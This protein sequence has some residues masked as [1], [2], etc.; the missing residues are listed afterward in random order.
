MK[1]NK[2]IEIFRELVGDNAENLSGSFFPAYANTKI[3]NALL[4]EN[5]DLEDNE[6]VEVDSIGMDLVCWQR[7]AAFI[8]ALVLFP[9]KFTDEDIQDEVASLLIHMPD[10]IKNALKGYHK[11]SEK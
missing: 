2:V 4:K 6:I 10:H 3:T 9:D 5:P 11:L 7:D 1:K 8:V